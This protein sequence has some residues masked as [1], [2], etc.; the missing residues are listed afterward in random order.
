M[1]IPQN[2][3]LRAQAGRMEASTPPKKGPKT[4]R[5]DFSNGIATLLLLGTLFFAVCIFIDFR[6]RANDRGRRARVTAA[7][8]G[9]SDLHPAPVGTRMDDRQ[10]L[11]PAVDMRYSPL[12]PF[13]ESEPGQWVI[14]SRRSARTADEV[15]GPS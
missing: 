15:K 3:T 5:L 12:L 14:H 1:R 2:V 6:W 8:I 10:I 13:A 11:H 7:E 9:V 4:D